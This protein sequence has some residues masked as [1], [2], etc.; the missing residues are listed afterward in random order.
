MFRLLDGGVKA[1]KMKTSLMSMF[2]VFVASVIGSFGS[3]YFKKGANDLRFSLN[4]IL[5]N[6]KL[7]FGFFL[8]IFSACI[9]VISLKGGELSV[10]YPITALTY[11]WINFLSKKYLN[12]E[13]SALKWTGVILIIIG[14][15]FIGVGN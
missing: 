7:V 2:L 10:L 13:M 4:A 9:F 5:K 11:I 12:E 15:T 8:Y 6:Y 14:V 3:L 1:N